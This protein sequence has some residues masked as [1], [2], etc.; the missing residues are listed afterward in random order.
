MM[1]TEDRELLDAFAKRV[2]AVVPS[3]AIW[4]FGSRARGS[5]HP[6]SDLDLLVVVPEAT[7]DVR[8]SV[9]RS[10]WEIGFEHER[11][12]APV[13]LTAENFEH[14][15]MSASTLVANVRRDGVAA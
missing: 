9:P 6:D 13:I 3:A 5:A 15:P 4:A 10:A 8:E 7:R 2:R 12:L 1:S 14:G 11:L